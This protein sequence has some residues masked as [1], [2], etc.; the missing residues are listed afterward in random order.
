MH[1]EFVY[2]QADREIS[3]FL[4]ATAIFE[5]HVQ[6]IHWKVAEK[7]QKQE[8]KEQQVY[9]INC[10]TCFLEKVASLPGLTLSHFGAKFLNLPET[11]HAQTASPLRADVEIRLPTAR[12]PSTNKAKS[13]ALLQF[14]E[15]L[16]NPLRMQMTFF[17]IALWPPNQN[18]VKRW[19]QFMEVN[20]RQKC[21]KNVCAWDSLKRKRNELVNIALGFTTVY[22]PS[23]CWQQNFAR[24]FY[25]LFDF[26]IIFCPSVL[27]PL[28]RSR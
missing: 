22:G 17:G 26:W 4:L 18:I 25:D 15:P 14:C 5:Q 21:S 2:K 3:S 6:W 27:A 16:T 23:N 28:P 20:F 12:L 13:S 24:K 1:D 10:N 7:L 9:Q 11:M 19:K 8:E